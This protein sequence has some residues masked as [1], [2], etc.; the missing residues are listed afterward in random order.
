MRNLYKGCVKKENMEEFKK[1]I[2]ALKKDLEK[3]SPN[4]IVWDF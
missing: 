3:L 2:I 1:E 4:Q